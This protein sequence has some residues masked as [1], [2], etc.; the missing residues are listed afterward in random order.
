MVSRIAKKGSGKSRIKK[1]A[2]VKMGP[3]T[4]L[5]GYRLRRAQQHVFRDFAT[6][7]TSRNITP[8]QTGLLILIRENPGI[9]QT[10]LARAV[11][12]ERST[13]GEI[14]E[15]LTAR[16]LV[17]RNRSQKDRR[18]FALELSPEGAEFLGSLLEG[19]S[20]HEQKITR[21]LNDEERKTLMQLLEK[22][23]G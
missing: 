8:G 4:S 6:K 1:D 18:S 3:L 12:I 9:S 11:G 15:R 22:L 2:P 23:V 20:G 17:S 7:F 10:A 5:L 13:L 14:I 19:I 21:H 16:H